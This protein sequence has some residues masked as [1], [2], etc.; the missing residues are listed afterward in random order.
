MNNRHKGKVAIVTGAAQG[1]GLACARRFAE[2]GA[3]VV[4]ADIQGE[5]ALVQA[6]MF[7]AAGFSAEGAACDVG[8]VTHFQGLVAR[9]A[10]EKGRVD[11][12][13]NNAATTSDPG[14]LDLSE[15]EYDRVMDVDLK[16]VFFGSQA[17]A[18]V[19]VKQGA[20]A[21][22][23]MSSM[24]AALAIPNRVPYGIAKGGIN[25]MTK[26]FALAL[27]KQGVRVNAVGPGTIVTALAR[28][29]VLANEDSYRKILSRTPMGR[30][31][32]PS[33]IA[34]VV[35]FLA[36]DDASYVTG[37]C[38]YA[39]GGRLTLNYTVDVDDELPDLSDE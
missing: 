20:G 7:V 31:G 12:L 16:G 2:D 8:N 35:S 29:K 14:V 38:I 23:N 34:S 18:R 6:E 33:E 32:Q 10:E 5:E 15:E 1:I 19:M 27:A 37:Q 22:I 28:Q 17:A 21:I 36:S 30:C 9:I 26:I 13:V 11:I 4:L 3:H 25:Q 24:Q 39:D